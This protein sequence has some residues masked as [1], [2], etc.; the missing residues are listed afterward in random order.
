MENDSIEK[1]FDRFQERCDE[2]VRSQARIGEGIELLAQ[3]LSEIDLHQSALEDHVGT[4]LVGSIEEMRAELTRLSNRLDALEG[5]LDVA[6]HRVPDG[7]VR[8]SS[9]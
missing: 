9:L 7:S 3:V 6:L 4:T 2:M 5:A 8:R 1:R